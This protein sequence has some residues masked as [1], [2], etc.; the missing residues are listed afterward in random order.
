[1]KIIIT[2]ADGFVGSNLIREL[3]TRNHEI[4]AFVKDGQDARNIKDLNI[5]IKYGDL[6]DPSTLTKAI[7]GCEALIHTAALTSMWPYR[8]EIQKKVNIEGTRNVME[9]VLSSGLKRVIHI[10]T[11][12]SFGFGSK[13]NPGDETKNYLSGKYKMDYMDTK[14]TAQELVLKMVREDNLPAIIVNPTFMFGPY[15]SIMGS[16]KMIELVYNGKIPGFTNGGRNYIAVKDVCVA[17]SNALEM[18]KIGESYILGN[19]NLNYKEIFTTIAKVTNAKAPKLFIPNLGVK[20]YGK[21]LT[22]LG[23]TFRFE[24]SVSYPMAVISCEEQ[25]YQSNKAIKELGLPQTPIKTALTEAF[26]W[27]QENNRCIKQ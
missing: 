15:A 16:A 22:I 24:P 25:Y 19:E 7:K 11:A 18:G 21:I 10:G 26:N 6:L 8:S 5:D 14:F 20:L 13:N 2:G 4:V 3:L 23:K 17:I 9:A 1:M 12:S 27:L